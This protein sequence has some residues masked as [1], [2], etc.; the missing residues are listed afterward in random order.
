MVIRVWSTCHNTAQ[1]NKL[2]LTTPSTLPYIKQFWVYAIL[3]VNMCCHLKDT[4]LFITILTHY[5][6]IRQPLNSEFFFLIQ[7]LYF[8]WVYLTVPSSNYIFIVQQIW[9]VVYYKAQSDLII[10]ISASHGHPKKA[11]VMHVVERIHCIKN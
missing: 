9:N 5:C 10:P 6:G 8:S 11:K 1:T 2:G 7:S 4:C 3:N